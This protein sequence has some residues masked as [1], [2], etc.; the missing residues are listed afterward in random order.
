M[1]PLSSITRNESS[2]TSAS[3]QKKGSHSWIMWTPFESVLLADKDA[4]HEELRKPHQPRKNENVGSFWKK[5]RFLPLSFW[6]PAENRDFA[7][8]TWKQ[9]R[10]VGTSRRI[11]TPL[12]SLLW[13][14]LVTEPLSQSWVLMCCF[15][16][17]SHPPLW[18]RVVAVQSAGK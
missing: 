9:K 18:N 10:K 1:Q 3:V 11:E 4:P 15:D 16:C 8:K 14:G 5:T 12:T 2:A 13:N 17:A 6:H 7:Q